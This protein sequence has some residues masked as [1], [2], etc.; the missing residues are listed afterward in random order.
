MNFLLKEMTYIRYFLPLIIE[1]NK[2]GIESDVFWYVCNK[3]NCPSK[4]VASLR[5]LSN[6]YKFN[7][8][9]VEKIKKFPGI[10]FLVEGRG[11]EFLDK[12]IHKSMSITYQDNFGIT[13]V[14]KL[15]YLRYIDDV[16]W[17]LL[18]N[19]KLAEKYLD[20]SGP[21][22]L[23]FGSPKYDVEINREKMLRQYNLEDKKY[24]L[25]MLPKLNKKGVVN[26][27]KLYKILE[28]RGYTILTKTRA[29]DSYPNNFSRGDHYY[30]DAC[31]FPHTSMGLMEISDFVVNFHSTC[32]K[33]CILL[34][35]PVL[36]FKCKK[37]E[38]HNMECL[39]D[40]KICV[41]L[42]PKASEEEILKGIDFLNSVRPDDFD[43]VIDEYLFTGNTSKKV[44]DF[45]AEQCNI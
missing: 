12:N 16:D 13:W 32:I 38:F 10:C 5:W 21:K 29:K 9:P 30:E 33:E 2:R 40:E 17:V 11:I 4:N 3:Y 22:N 19:K 23:F 31:W 24:V 14:D 36:N 39:Y 37:S 26:L 25:I 28:K 15:L 35:T 8:R 44:L 27:K 20:V 18:P 42:K 41:N 6:K 1:G 45:V 43:D 34:R 7:L